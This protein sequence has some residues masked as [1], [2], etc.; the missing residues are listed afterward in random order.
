[1][2][3]NGIYRG[4]MGGAELTQIT[5]NIRYAVKEGGFAV[6]YEG[7]QVADME[8]LGAVQ[9]TGLS[10]SA[11]QTANK[12]YPL[13]SDVQYYLLAGGKYYPSDRETILNG[14]YP[15][16]GWYDNARFGGRIRVIVAEK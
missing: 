11:A 12:S 15:L 3:V 13:A 16:T 1:M 2:S 4:Y 7:T 9:L 6:R 14:G 8:Q 10:A 5:T